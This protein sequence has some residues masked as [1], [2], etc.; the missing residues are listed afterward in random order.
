ERLAGV[1]EQGEVLGEVRHHAQER[2]VGS[3][4]HLVAPGHL[5]DRR[6]LVVALDQRPRA[7]FICLVP[8]R[9]AP[10]RPPPAPEHA[11]AVGV[12]A[13]P[14]ATGGGGAVRPRFAPPPGPAAPA[15][16]PLAAPPEELDCWLQVT[17]L[18][19]VYAFG[20]N[21]TSMGGSCE[22]GC[23]VMVSFSRAI[24]LL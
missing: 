11:V 21:R 12:G 20:L 1:A 19:M 4:R 16:P 7:H 23:G 22:G 2:E 24:G 5:A 14:P 6:L 18:M 17:G 9:G 15:A 10:P 13:P 8:D 3:V